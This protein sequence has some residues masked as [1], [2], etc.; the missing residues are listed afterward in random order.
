MTV[1]INYWLVMWSELSEMCY[2][3]TGSCDVGTCI[4]V[5]MEDG[6]FHMHCFCMCKCICSDMNSVLEI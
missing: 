2:V 5:L 4:M 1:F 6:I 3:V